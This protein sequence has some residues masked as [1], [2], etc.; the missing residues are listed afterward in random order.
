MES[1]LTAIQTTRSFAD[2]L[3]KEIFGTGIARWIGMIARRFGVQVSLITQIDRFFQIAALFGLSAKIFLRLFL[4]H[5][6]LEIIF[7][8]FFCRTRY[9]SFPDHVARG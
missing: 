3:P 8:V 9:L 2:A 5:Q 6:S 7:R 4:Q 1:F